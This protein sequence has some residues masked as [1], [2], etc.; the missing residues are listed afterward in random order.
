MAEATLIRILR[1]GD[2]D[3]PHHHDKEHKAGK[4]ESK[5]GPHITGPPVTQLENGAGE[6]PPRREAER[7]WLP[8]PVPQRREPPTHQAQTG[9]VATGSPP[10]ITVGTTGLHGQA[11]ER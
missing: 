3:H 2:S 6:A 9:P 7:G 5:R 10:R 4:A 1:G 8:A 11:T